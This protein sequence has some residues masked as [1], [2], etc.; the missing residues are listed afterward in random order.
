MITAP[1]A[2][3]PAASVGV[4]VGPLVHAIDAR[5][6]MAYAAA[7]GETEPLYY[8]TEAVAGPAPHPLFPVSY[9]WPLAVAIRERTID[10]ALAPFGVHATHHLVVHRPPRVGDRLATTAV[11]GGVRR[12]RAGTLMLVR[13]TTV[14]AAG[15]PVTTTD[16]GSLYRGI[17]GDGDAA[18]GPP[19]PTLG[20]VGAP[21]AP[22]WTEPID[23]A[24]SA[25]HVYTEGARIWN[26]IHTDIAV[27]RAAG[28]PG[29]I[30]HGTAT[31]ALAVSRV[32]RRELG[33]HP[34]RVRAVA[35]RFTSMV[36]LPSR[37]VVRAGRAGDHL[38]TFDAVDAGGVTVLA[39][40]A[41][42]T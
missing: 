12:T 32:V 22:T 21:A 27:A 15:A 8:D 34:G 5:W 41:V 14:D 18:L 2:I 6:L 31:L 28:L 25:A 30:L 23:I 42:A 11:V 39:Q 13:F 33:G 10:P 4:A 17:G 37:L 9:E 19:L 1:P 3:V 16:Y 29:L 36:P 20:G 7:V 35:V 26:P 38:V 40:G 24:P